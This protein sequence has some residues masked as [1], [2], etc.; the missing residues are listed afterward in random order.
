MQ[1]IGEV[2]RFQSTPK[3]THVMRVKRIFRNLKAK[4]YFGLWYP[5]GKEISLVAYTYVD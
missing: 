4:I 2:A 1:A 5:K 3:E